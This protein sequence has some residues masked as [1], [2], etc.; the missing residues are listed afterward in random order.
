MPTGCVTSCRRS[1]TGLPRSGKVLFPEGRRPS[2]GLLN[3]RNTMNCL[4]HP[5]PTEKL[6]LHIPWFCGVHCAGNL[7]PSCGGSHAV[8]SDVCHGP[9]TGWGH[10]LQA[11]TAGIPRRRAVVTEARGRAL[12]I[13]RDLPSVQITARDRR[14]GCLCAIGAT[15]CQASDAGICANIWILQAS[16]RCFLFVTTLAVVHLLSVPN[17]PI[18]ALSCCSILIDIP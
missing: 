18:T 6:S 4:S 8:S 1:P 16:S 5:R 13:P 10:N 14:A 9:Q 11:A 7:L 15:S 2:L 12:A 17:E 3:I